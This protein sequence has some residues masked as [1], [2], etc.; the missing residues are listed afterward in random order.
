MAWRYRRSGAAK[1]LMGHF[2]WTLSAARYGRERKLRELLILRDLHSDGWGDYADIAH[3]VVETCLVEGGL[4][5]RGEVAH[6]VSV[7]TAKCPKARC[8]GCLEDCHAAA[9]KMP[10]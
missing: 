3:R 7:P 4:A 1:D 10:A 5:A 2:A 8:L 6:D 9:R